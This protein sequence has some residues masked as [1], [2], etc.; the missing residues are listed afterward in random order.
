MGRWQQG[1]WYSHCQCCQR[2]RNPGGYAAAS[3]PGGHAAAAHAGL[4]LGAVA[5][6]ACGV[7][8]A[9]PAANVDACSLELG[10][11]GQGLVVETVS[12]TEVVAAGG[13]LGNGEGL[14]VDVVVEHEARGRSPWQSRTP[15]AHRRSSIAARTPPQSPSGQS[16]LSSVLP[17]SP[18]STKATSAPAAAPKGMLSE[19]LSPKSFCTPTPSPTHPPG[20]IA[21]MYAS[22]PVASMHVFSSR[23][24]SLGHTPLSPSRQ[25]FGTTPPTSL[26]PVTPAADSPLSSVGTLTPVRANLFAPLVPSL[27]PAPASQESPRPPAPAGRRKTMA[28]GF[29]VRRSSIRIRTSHKGTP[30]AKMAERNLCQRLGILE[31]N[32]DVTEATVQ[33]FV[34]MFAS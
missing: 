32:E 11:P 13:T 4:D 28:G 15:A 18:F 14:D 30:I 24:A 25:L 31:E 1:H 20:F 6:A 21:A 2:C 5:D 29:T 22:A 27:L 33:E 19:L 7:A 9:G 12:P 16:S 17:A 23:L 10:L 8:G 34:N 26:P 3:A